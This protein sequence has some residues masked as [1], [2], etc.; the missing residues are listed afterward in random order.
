MPS[1]LILPPQKFRFRDITEQFPTSG[2][3][4]KKVFFQAE[5]RGISG[6]NAT[7]GVIAYPSW[8]EGNKWIVGTK[9]SGVDSG[10]EPKTEPLNVPIGFANNEIL[11]S[12]KL[13]KKNKKKNRKK[14]SRKNPRKGRWT[15][16]MRV[17]RRVCK[18]AKLLE[19]SE[20]LF[21]AR[22]S[23][24]PHL[25]YDVTMDMGGTTLSVQTKPSPP[26]PPEA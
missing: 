25:E 22:I 2:N 19:E 24:N 18:D 21:E 11:L 14:R 10:A 8:K 3:P 20:L 1:Q 15:E 26:A 5:L 6:G 13:S 23:E 7:F 17:A 4:K 12:L 9:V 16:F